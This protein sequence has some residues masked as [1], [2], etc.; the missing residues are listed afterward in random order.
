MT[1][2][3]RKTEINIMKFVGAT[4]TFIRIPY[5]IEGILLG[6]IASALAFFVQWAV[7]DLLIV[8]GLTKL[9][10]FTPLTFS[11]FAPY[12]F[13]LYIIAAVGFGIF[14]SLLPMRKYLNV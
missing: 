2:Y 11:Y 9:A 8:N 12:M 7:Y 1:I 6:L 13:V 10:F 5:I 3:A 14:G 4:D